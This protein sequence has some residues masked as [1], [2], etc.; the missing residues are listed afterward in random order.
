MKHKVYNLLL[1]VTSL[2]GYLEWSGTSH[3]F[4]FQAELELFKKLFSTPKTAAHPFTIIPFF[5]Q[6]LLLIT[7]F[8]KKSNKILTYFGIGCLGLLL[9]FILFIGLLSLNYKI[10]LSTIPFIVVA[11]AAILSYKKV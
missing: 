1:I 9:L 3:A 5:G 4:L 11:I 7:L 2:L 6:L 10:A 8:Q